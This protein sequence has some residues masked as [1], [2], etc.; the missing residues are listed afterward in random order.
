MAPTKQLASARGA[1]RNLASASR[2]T[3]DALGDP[4]LMK[5]PERPQD[6][7]DALRHQQGRAG[8]GE[9]DDE[10]GPQQTGPDRA[11]RLAVPRRERRA[12]RGDKHQ[13]EQPDTSIE[14]DH[15][16]GECLGPGGPR[17]VADADD[18]STDVR[19]QEV[20]EEGRD[21]KGVRQRA[22]CH[23]D[24]LC[25]RAAVP[26]A[27]R[28][29]APSPDRGQGPREATSSRPSAARATAVRDRPARAART[30]G[31]RLR[32]LLTIQIKG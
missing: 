21:E 8:D 2:Q 32:E 10:R 23:V 31:R 25:A 1:A 6:P 7:A 9:P 28:S 24:V 17:R 30:A 13:A 4:F 19:R 3:L 26:S 15:C 12:R 27:T 5:H 20:V 22:E 14:Q 18:V 11:E 16:R 29:R